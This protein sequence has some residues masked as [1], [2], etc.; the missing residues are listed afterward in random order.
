MSDDED[1]KAIAAARD[2]AKQIE[3]P[4]VP[5]EVESHMR[6][7]WKREEALLSALFAVMSSIGGPAPVVTASGIAPPDFQ[8]FFLRNLVVP[9]NRFRPMDS[10]G[11]HAVVHSQTRSLQ[12]IFL[13][14][15][16]VQQISDYISS[17]AA[18]QQQYSLNDL[19]QLISAWIQFVSRNFFPQQT[20]FSNLA[21]TSNVGQSVHR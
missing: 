3:L 6:E 1:D 13:A 10:S 7:M 4:I 21:Q 15:R 20:H 16:R 5:T 18:K 2:E 9:P 14:N 19:S 11:N 8:L 12:D 17:T